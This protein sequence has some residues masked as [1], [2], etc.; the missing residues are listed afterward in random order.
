MTTRLNM[1]QMQEAMREPH[2]IRN[3][4][5]IAHVDHGKSTL[6]DALVCRAGLMSEK[7]AG[8]KLFTACRDDEIERGITIKS[9]AVSMHFEVNNTGY[10][11]NLI[12]SPG[13]VDFS[14][15][16]TAALRVTDGA[17]CVVDV[18]SGVSNQTETVLRQALSERIKP[19]LVINKL[20]RAI[21]E[22]KLEPEVLYQRLKTIIEQVNYLI[23]VYS[24]VKPEESS[25]VEESSEEGNKSNST[26]FQCSVLD[27]SK[28]NVAFASGRDGWAFTLTQFAEF[29]SKKKK[30]QHSSSL[31]Q[32]LWGENYYNS[33]SGQWQKTNESDEGKLKR[34]FIQY[35]L[36]PLYR[37]LNVCAENDPNS[38]E[39]D[40]LCEKLNVKLKLE[41]GRESLSGRDLTRN[42]MKKWLPAADALLELITEHLPSPRVAQRYRVAHLYEGPLDDPVAIGIRECDSN[43]HLMIFISKML[44]DSSDSNKFLAFG[45]VFSGTARLGQSVRIMAP[46]YQPGSG[47]HETGLFIKNLTR[48][49]CMIGDQPVSLDQVPCGNVIALAGIDKM[50]LKSGTIS[51]YELAHTIRS[52]KFSVSA[53]VR[54][55][56][57]PENPA[58][59]G[60]FLEGLKRL[61]R[62]DQLVQCQVDKGQYVVCGAGELHLE[63]CLRDLETKYARVPI[64]RSEPTVQYKETVTRLSDQVCLAKTSNKLNRL[65]M[66]AQPLSEEFCSD[67]D[68]QKISLNQD[69]R[70]R[71]KYL[72][73][74]HGFDSTE[75]KKI[76]CFGPNQ[77]D[78]NILIDMTKGVASSGDVT[79]TLCAGFQWGT[80]EGVLCGEELRGVRFNLVDLQY[81]ADAAHRKGNQLLPAMRRVMMSSMLTAGPR[82]MEPVYLVDVQCP[83]SA[84]GAVYTLLNRKRGVVIEEGRIEGTLLNRVKAYMPV[85]ESTGFTDQ[86]RGVTGGRAFQNSVFDHWQLLPGDPFEAE[87]CAGKVC[88]QIRKAKGLREQMPML[89]DYI[90][91]L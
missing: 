60:K 85:N 44:P 63:V 82:L 76:W 55:A 83:E 12:D 42:F 51:S 79:D 25:S 73:T 88:R 2:R 17:L 8:Q 32:K 48:C 74:V 35:I 4:S 13:H 84:I 20:D 29:Y 81:H 77:F 52:M 57:Q 65:F 58:D 68:N 86:L 5:V 16:V 31:V 64:R 15:E 40:H 7:H 39:F 46:G 89:A 19:V 30:K 11:V 67:I 47:S 23:Y 54:V 87:S 26:S 72:Q 38:D 1:E 33:V 36:D 69:V 56:V 3:I 27:P 22:Q 34:G 70:E 75:A 59:L 49:V 90:D 28:G 50:L 6:T 53:V 37:C 80:E 71:A 21:M 24:D 61:S 91:K 66:T 78:A 9:T 41:S 10:L 43:A 18:V 14:S 62:S 45:R